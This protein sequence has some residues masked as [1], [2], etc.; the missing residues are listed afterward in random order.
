L[1]SSQCAFLKEQCTKLAAK[2]IEYCFECSG[3]PC[4]RLKKLDGRYRDEYGMSMIENLRYIQ[5]YGI[6][7]FLK[8]EQEK[9]KCPACGGTICVHNKTCYACRQTQK[10]INPTPRPKLR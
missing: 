2:Q 8:N 10:K 3:F 4:E 6:K 5:T 9:W 1:R 7:K